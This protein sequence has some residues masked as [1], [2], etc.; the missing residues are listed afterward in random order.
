MKH[1][2]RY[3]LKHL[4]V[5]VP[6]HD[7]GWNGS[8]CKNPKANG[9]CLILKNCALNR[10]DDKETANAG[11]FLNVLQEDDY[12][13]CIDERATFM[14]PFSI[15]KTTKHPYA[16]CS[17]AHKQLE[18]TTIVFP[19]YSAAAIPYNWML[20][21]NCEEKVRLYDLDFD[22][23]REPELK[24]PKD[25]DK[26]V[27]EINN[28]KALL[29]C[30]FEHLKEDVSLVFFYAKQV[31]FYEERGR[32]LIGVG[33]IK[34]IIPSEAYEGSNK[35]FGAAYWEHMILHSVRPKGTDGFLLPYHEAMEYEKEHPDFNISELTVVV[36]R[37]KTFEFSFASEHVSND[38]A[39]RI[40]LD[41]IKSLERADA[42]G[43]GE[44]NNQKIKWIH[45]EIASLEKLRGIYPGMGAALCTF[46]IEKGHFVAAEIINK[47]KD[48]KENP[49]LIFE[50]ALDNHQGILSDSVNA[51]IP[52]NSKKLYKKLKE[53][54][55]NNRI[56][57]LHLLSR[58]DLT[59]EQAEML[60]IEEERELNGIKSKDEDY[61]KN[62]YLVYEHLLHTIFPVSL[63]TIDL[64]MY[65]KNSDVQI[66]PD[67]LFYTDPFKL[68]RIR[69]ITVQQ[70][71][72]VSSIGHTL[73]PRKELIKQIRDLSITPECQINSDYFE[74][75]EECFA[76][77]INLEEMKNG[78]R[79]YQL[80]RYTKTRSII[81][82]K[83]IDR[84]G[85]KRLELN[86]DWRKLL[87]DALKNSV[88]GSLNEMEEKAREEKAAALKEIGEARFSVLIGPAGTGKTT[89]LSI[90]AG[91][92]EVE[93]KGVLLLAP[94]GKAR[95][96]ME[97][98]AKN[99]RVTTKT[100]ALF[101][102]EYNRF[103]GDTNR[104]IFSEKHCE[105]SYETVILDEASM[106][107]EEMLATTL[108]C[109]KGVKRF[110]LVGDHRQLPPIGAGRPFIDI[111]NY[112]KPVDIETNFPRVGKGYAE[113]TIKCRQ[114][115]SKREDMQL[116]EWFSG[117][118]LEPG[119][120]SIINEIAENPNTNFLRVEYWNNED[121]FEKLFE[122]VLIEELE[123]NS[124]SDVAK[125]NQTLGSSDGRFFNFR[126]SVSKAESWQILSPLRE[127]PIGVKAINR[128]IHK[129]F[130]E[131]KIKYARHRNGKIPEPV[132]L[133]EIVYGDKIINL[134]NSRRFKDSVWPQENSLNYIANGEIG[135]IIGQFK[136]K[137]DKYDGKPKNINIEF[138]SQKGFI[139]TFKFWE[140]GEENDPP[141]ELAYALT[142]HKAQGSEFDKVL[143]IVP[144]PCFLLTREMLYTALT[145]QKEKVIML[146]QGKSFDI[147]EF[148]SPLKSDSLKRITNLFVKPELVEVDGQYLEKNLIHQAADGKMLRSKSELLI[149][150]RLLDKHLNPLYEKKLILKEV[151]KLPDFTIEN[152][153]SG[154]TY[155]WEH[156][157]M[158]Y[159]T[160]YKRRWDEKYKWYLENNI[161]PFE[162]GGG[163]NGTLIVTKDLPNIIEDGSIRGSISI[164]E[165]DELIFKIFKV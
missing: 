128:K 108:D 29:N 144:N 109:L 164:K 133:E 134:Y 101:L 73:L 121:D 139:Y 19:S 7:S 5:R 64:G 162:D 136:R 120:D 52:E 158:L 161:L 35:R 165:V 88:T 16:K 150:Q 74:L 58:F 49:W 23:E 116:A 152:E 142:V 12:P 105:G 151:E 117:E 57:F 42:L 94:T 45:D 10:K 47:M 155:Y 125:F 83:I 111:I 31:P 65:V 148:A 93:S 54:T 38:A 39:I 138:T 123:M 85:G 114:G 33:K 160:E 145:R 119:A 137:N 76:E 51:L 53:K 81:C 70:L 127:K 43:I 129:H 141:L 17:E 21:K 55:E 9:A 86:S 27:Q 102:S 37:D 112:L 157:G 63:S 131:D 84:I 90:L 92:K 60:F 159:D 32:V 15:S 163:E 132:G 100:L 154:K 78:E 80:I 67:N 153:E 36:P 56:N 147:A 59:I 18:K 61:L 135:M 34:K 46:G 20:K 156:C 69:A 98:V 87:D 44:N 118:P 77:C 68:N 41:C 28:Q 91:H 48:D 99:L 2:S 30:F 122:K 3:T 140:F 113:L 4:S 50:K 103:D 96:R 130:R 107:T 11:K 25:K 22:L 62:P 82:K 79:A 14:A 66:L 143:L 104:Y 6:W 13:V 26:W 124:Y 72:R 110:I 71:E 8:I 24:I 89:L 40:L 95:V 106:I 126:E 149:Y 75:A 146:Y 97:E 115:G 1:N